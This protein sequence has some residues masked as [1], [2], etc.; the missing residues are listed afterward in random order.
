[1]PEI[2]NKK[3]TLRLRENEMLLD[4]WEALRGTASAPQRSA[5]NPMDLPGHLPRLVMLEPELPR[6]A[7][8]R[9]F[10]TE[11]AR[12]LGVDLTG[13][14][15]F[16]AYGPGQD[17]DVRELVQ[18]VSDRQAVAVAYS[19]WST[20]SGHEFDTENLWLPFCSEDGAVTRILGSL[21]EL[22]KPDTDIEDLGGSINTAQRLSERSFYR[23]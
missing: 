5:F 21:W 18:C 15:L 23:F 20:P 11:L 2:Q 4:H 17:G 16:Q 13:M 10:G 1:M 3:P 8:I 22:E 14:D 6:R 7:V 19:R 12:R 9:T